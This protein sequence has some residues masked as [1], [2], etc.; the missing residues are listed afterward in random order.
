M[1]DI[2]VKAAS[3]EVEEG[4]EGEITKE[5]VEIVEG[6]VGRIKGPLVAIPE[7]ETAMIDGLSRSQ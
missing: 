3:K 4:E 6:E 7:V 5:V 2:L 1:S